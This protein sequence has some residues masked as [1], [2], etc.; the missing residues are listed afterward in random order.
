MI[1]E[2]PSDIVLEQSLKFEFQTSHNQTENEA[3][4]PGMKLV[5]EMGRANFW[6]ARAIPNWSLDKSRGTIRQRMLS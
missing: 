6:C 1:L 2:G 5:K 3:L 4:I